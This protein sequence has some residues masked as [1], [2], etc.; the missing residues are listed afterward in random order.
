MSKV[1]VYLVY[2]LDKLRD[3]FKEVNN[4]SGKSNNNRTR[5][6]RRRE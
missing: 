4:K 6:N 5:Y 3:N 1:Q 2:L